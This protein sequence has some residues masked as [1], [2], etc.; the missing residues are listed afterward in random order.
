MEKIK[1]NGKQ[2][3]LPTSWDDVDMK[4]YCKCFYKLEDAPDKA[5][6]LDVSIITLR[7]ESKIISRLLG[8]DDDFVS[9]CPVEVFNLLRDRVKFIYEIKQYL[10]SKQFYINID[11]KKYFMPSPNEMSLRQFIDADIIMKQ[12]SENQFIELLA[13]LLLPMNDDGS[14][15]YDGNYGDLIPKIGRMNAGDVL[16]FIYTFYKKK[17][18][19][20]RL[21]EDFSKVE[22]AAGQFQELIKNS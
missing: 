4:L 9:K 14:Y 3:K 15:N 11:G 18:I 12:D 20:K 1:I 17:E 10:D 22:Q 21:S 13:C 19:S 5:D 7:N 2:Y 16:P 6:D 8:E